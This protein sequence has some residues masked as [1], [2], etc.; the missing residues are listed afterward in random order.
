MN[1]VPKVKGENSIILM[2]VKWLKIMKTYPELY[3]IRSKYESKY[4]LVFHKYVQILYANQKNLK[5]IV[6]EKKKL[7]IL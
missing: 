6:K 3:T 1:I 5:V 4:N 7:K 2:T